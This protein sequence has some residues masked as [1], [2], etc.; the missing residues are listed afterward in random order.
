MVAPTALSKSSPSDNK[1]LAGFF[2]FSKQVRDD[3]VKANASNPKKK[4]GAAISK[5]VGKL[6]KA[7]PEKDKDL[8]KAG[9]IPK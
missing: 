3:V 5:E 9:K 7:L 4:K 8:Y 1:P 2:L 6:W